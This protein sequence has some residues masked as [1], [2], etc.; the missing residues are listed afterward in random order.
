MKPSYGRSYFVCSDQW[1]PCSFWAWGDVRPTAK[2]KCRHGSPCVIHKF[3]KEGVNKDRLFFCCGQQNKCKYFEWVPE[4]PYFFKPL[5]TK[6]IEKTYNFKNNL[7]AST[8]T[9]RYSDEIK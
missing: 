2:P 4:E 9:R 5:P 1:N 7:N 8:S 3:K 6:R